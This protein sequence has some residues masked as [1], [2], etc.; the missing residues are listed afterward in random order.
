[1]GLWAAL[2]ANATLTV[3]AAGWLEG[4]LC[5][6]YEKFINDIE[7]VQTIAE[8]CNPL[9]EDEDSF[10]WSALADVEPGGHFF[11][12]D[13]TMQRYKD[14][15]YSPLVADLNNHGGWVESGAKTSSERATA[16]WKKALKDHV[17]PQHSNNAMEN[18][19]DYIERRIAQGGT[20]QTDG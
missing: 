11:A 16:L 6:G 14:A 9:P 10:G 20:S 7:A 15:F 4:G 19:S 12:T 3:H 13:H 1:M 5:F 17:P 18:I 8:L 2:Q